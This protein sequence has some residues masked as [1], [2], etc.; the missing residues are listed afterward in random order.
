M[1]TKICVKD[2]YA[3]G[4]EDA[5]E[6]IRKFRNLSERERDKIF[7]TIWLQDILSH[8]KPLEVV[9]KIKEYEERQKQDATDMNDGSI[10]VGDEIINGGVVGVVTH[11]RGIEYGMKAFT[12]IDKTGKVWNFNDLLAKRTGRNFPQIAE[13]LRQLRG[14]E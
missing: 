3:K 10:K 11:V 9:Q 14:E 7:D 13:V 6:C 12:L 2:A 8:F 1:D 5:W 4:L